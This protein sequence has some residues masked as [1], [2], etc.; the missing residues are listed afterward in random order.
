MGKGSME[1]RLIENWHFFYACNDHV[2][3]RKQ[4]TLR[5]NSVLESNMRYKGCYEFWAKTFLSI[6]RHVHA[7]LRR[8]TSQLVDWF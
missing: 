5:Y 6:H 4:G 7:T 1:P 8:C 3:S 2:P